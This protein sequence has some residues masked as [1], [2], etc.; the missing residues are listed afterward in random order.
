M[1]YR[2]SNGAGTSFNTAANW[3]E[4]V[5][6]PSIH[7]TTNITVTAGGVLS[8]TFTAPNLVNACTGVLVPVAAR[9]TAGSII[10]T[11]QHDVG[12]GFVDCGGGSTATITITALV[13][14]THTF[15][16]F[17]T[18]FVFAT[19]TADRYRIK[20]NTSGAS[21]TTSIAA[22]SGAANF[23][24]I[25]Y[26]NNNVV[27]GAGDDI[28]IVSPNQSTALTIALDSSPSLGS[29][30]NT[31]DPTFRSWQNALVLANLGQLAFPTASSRTITPMGNILV[32]SGG[33]YQKGQTS[34]P[35]A[36][37]ITAR[38]SF[39]QN[40][41]NVNYGFK[42]LTGGI[43]TMQSVA[44]TY[45]KTTLSSGVGTAA[46]PF[47][48]TDSVD[49]TVGDELCFVPVSSSATNYDET[50]TRFIITKNSATSYVLSATA[51]GGEVAFTYSHAAGTVFNLTRGCVIDTTNS[52]Y[53]WYGDFQEVTTSSNTDIDGARFESFGSATASK[54]T[55]IFANISTEDAQVD[56]AV[57]YR[58]QGTGVTLQ[59]SAAT[60]THT[61]LIFYD[62]N[63]VG[64]A[65][66][67]FCGARNKSYTNCY[68]IDSQSAGFFPVGGS[69][70]TFTDCASWAC[71][72]A[73]ATAYG[74]W[75]TQVFS[76]TQTR[77][78]SHANRTYGAYHSNTA[79]GYSID[80]F[81]GSKGTNGVCDIFPVSDAF[82]DMVYENCAFGSTTLI[83]NYLNLAPSSSINFQ[84]LNGT[85]NVHRWYT[86][87]GI[88]RSTG[89][90][91]ADTTTLKVGHL[92]AR[93]DPEEATI[94]QSFEFRILAR[95]GAAAQCFGMIQK[96]AAM[97]AD[98]V[99][100]NLY[101][102][103]S[104]T[105]D[106]TYVMPTDSAINVFNVGVTYS[107]TVPLFARVVITAKSVAVGAYVYIGNFF[108]GT[109]VLN[110]FDV[111]YLGK[112]S[113]VMVEQAGDAQAVWAVLTD[114]LT[115]AGTTGKV[116]KDTLTQGKYLALK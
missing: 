2:V 24:Y 22:D 38:T 8:A 58:S 79:S 26:M 46:S 16:R 41:V 53:A 74:G 14:S 91:L 70:M 5:N 100:V 35:I 37:G 7:A 44:K 4:G 31:S 71:G 20:L 11:L 66:A 48:A 39:N 72:R 12:A 54:T 65:G 97:A 68:C 115:I 111:W 29:G 49:W 75:F 112:P 67:F 98:E 84:K 101:L 92:S 32:E 17:T 33:W 42:K 25:A 10:A 82:V 94:G 96:N 86:L 76:L 113:D 61:W 62:Y 63:G 95:V 88:G 19:T 59:A 9:G 80:G 109:D 60:R 108:N 87:G 93:L 23:A 52:T 77:C 50:E 15:F 27:P 103:G 36:A 83:T 85:T 107:G 90:G 69:A 18:P 43:V 106:D 114:T 57:F 73:S 47:V 105:P 34:A 64:N 104:I 21:G 13:A 6:T 55:I 40:G 56:D 3:D 110:A 45:K 51:G 1:A 89:A 81:Y 78:E 28:H 30:G 99:T 102:P 116:Q